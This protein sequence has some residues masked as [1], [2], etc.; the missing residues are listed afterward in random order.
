MQHEPRGK[1]HARIVD[2]TL[3]SQPLGKNVMFGGPH[4]SISQATNLEI[5]A[6]LIAGTLI[7]LGIA[8]VTFISSNRQPLWFIW[9]A[10]GFTVVWLVSSW[11][12][13]LR[14]LKKRKQSAEQQQW[15]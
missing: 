1:T 10:R 5:R 6:F 13:S 8:A 2:P 7:A 9:L 11:H 15:K 14:E 12:C 3:S 4:K